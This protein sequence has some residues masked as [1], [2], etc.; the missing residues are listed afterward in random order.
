MSE[1]FAERIQ[2]ALLSMRLGMHPKSIEARERWGFDQIS[3]KSSGYQQYLRPVG[4]LCFPTRHG[5][6]RQRR[7][8]SSSLLSRVLHGAYARWNPVGFLLG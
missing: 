4:K 3:R 5:K 1:G 8:V 7:D 6:V 2:D